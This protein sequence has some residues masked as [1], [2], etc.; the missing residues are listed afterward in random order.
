M[1]LACDDA[2][3]ICG[4]LCIEFPDVSAVPAG[5]VAANF[6]GHFPV[7]FDHAGGI[8]CAGSG[9]VQMGVSFVGMSCPV[10]RVFATNLCVTMPVSSLFRCC[11]NHGLVQH[12]AAGRRILWFGRFRRANFLEVHWLA[13]LQ[14]EQHVARPIL[15][16]LQWLWQRQPARWHTKQQRCR[17]F[18]AFG[19]NG[20]RCRKHHRKGGRLC[21]QRRLDRCFSPESAVHL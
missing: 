5:S 16:D 19:H 20:V 2:A 14:P 13:L 18:V 12:H 9:H 8:A 15:L 21:G 3:V 1:L 10:E 7:S 6:T 11:C 4:K 17:F